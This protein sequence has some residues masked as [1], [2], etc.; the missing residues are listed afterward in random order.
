MAPFPALWN[1]ENNVAGRDNCLGEIVK[2]R[3]KDEFDSHGRITVRLTGGLRCPL[4]HK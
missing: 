3:R 1:G 4:V 2:E